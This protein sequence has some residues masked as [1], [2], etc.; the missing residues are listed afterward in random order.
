MV[1]SP[2]DA[3]G[4]L[5]ASYMES[6]GYQRVIVYNDDEAYC[7]K[8]D[9]ID[10]IKPVQDH[11]SRVRIEEYYKTDKHA[12]AN[13]LATLG[14]IFERKK[15]Y[16][17]S[18]V[19]TDVSKISP[20]DIDWEKFRKAREQYIKGIIDSSG[21]P[22]PPE[23]VQVFVIK[24]IMGIALKSTKTQDSLQ[25]M[26]AR[27]FHYNAGGLADY[28][29]S[30]S[31]KKSDSAFVLTPCFDHHRTVIRNSRYSEKGYQEYLALLKAGHLRMLENGG[32]SLSDPG[33][34]RRKRM[35]IP[36]FRSE[37]VGSSASSQ[38]DPADILAS[39]RIDLMPVEEEDLFAEDADFRSSWEKA[40]KESI[41]QS[42]YE[43]SNVIVEAADDEELENLAEE[44]EFSTQ[45][46]ESIAGIEAE[47]ESGMS[48]SRVDSSEIQVLQKNL[49]TLR[50]V[51][52]DYD[53]GRIN[54]AGE[55]ARA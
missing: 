40:H 52:R 9:L 30:A 2:D 20:R 7:L 16:L 37:S 3:L 42:D 33:E 1:E 38:E 35:S 44:D 23:Q 19:Q 49:E 18:L 39:T 43:V 41:L 6:T 31:A 36:F 55:P 54:E 24:S 25:G 53:D 34:K 17:N 4:Y 12:E 29:D 5:A 48:D 51:K 14:F 47:I 32:V 13:A 45:L 50:Q 15:V 27:A 21:K 22:V 8:T 10:A 46:S 28:G 26:F 11:G